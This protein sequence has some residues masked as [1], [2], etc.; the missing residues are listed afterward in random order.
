MYDVF[1]QWHENT[2]NYRRFDG[3]L[4]VV[5]SRPIKTLIQSNTFAANWLYG[6]N[7]NYSFGSPDILTADNRGGE[8]AINTNSPGPASYDFGD[9]AIYVAE[10]EA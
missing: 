6:Y 3:G 10:V 8:I 2:S 1:I 7:D 9:G 5:N 4:E